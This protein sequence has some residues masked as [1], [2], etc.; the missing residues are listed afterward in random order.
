VK[1]IFAKA[2]VDP[3]TIGNP[4]SAIKISLETPQERALGLALLQFAETLDRVVSDYRPNHLTAYLFELATCYSTFFE[5]CPVLKAETD[6]LRASRLALCDLTARTIERGLN[7]L[8]I[9]VVER[10]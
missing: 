10:M 2:G 6:E 8:G 4:Q 3:S 9:E 5:N 7:L 1:S